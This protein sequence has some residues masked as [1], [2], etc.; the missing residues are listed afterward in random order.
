MVGV[1]SIAG[2]LHWYSYL[3]TGDKVLGNYLNT[4]QENANT[5]NRSQQQLSSYKGWVHASDPADT[6]R[7]GV[8]RLR[9]PW[10]QL[11]DRGSNNRSPCK[12]SWSRHQDARQRGVRCTFALTD[13]PWR[14]STVPRNPNPRLSL[15]KVVIPKKGKRKEWKWFMGSCELCRWSSASGR[16]YQPR[17]S[18][19]RGFAGNS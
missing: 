8:G 16:G 5:A 7:G 14:N 15:L 4:F 12:N 18:L 2:K 17:G 6:V 9:I 10:T 11:Q 1:V 19:R 3:S 13:N